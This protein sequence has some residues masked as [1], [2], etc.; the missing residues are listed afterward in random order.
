MKKK[1][2]ASRRH[3]RQNVLQVRVMTPRIAWLRFL[4][5]FG[6]LTKLACV[7]AI[8]AALGWAVWR[9]MQ[10]A[11]YRNPDFRLQVIDLNANPVIDEIRLASVIGLDLASNPSLFDINVEQATEQLKALP[12]IVDVTLERHLPDTLTVRV[13]PRVPK[14]W[15]RCEESGITEVRETGGLLVD[16]DGVAYHCPE[17]QI[18]STRLLPVI[19]L[20]ASEDVTMISG[21]RIDQPELNCALA[22]IKAICAVD[23]DGMRWIDSIR[24]A[25]M[26]S[27][28]LVTRDGT[29]ATFGLG[30]HQRQIE[31]L[32][33]ALAHAGSRGYVIDTIN[34][35]PKYN[36]PITIRSEIKPPKAIPVVID[37]TAAMDRADEKKSTAAATRN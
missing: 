27:L 11:F 37:E 1:S 4:G 16:Q 35:I 20:P 9:G 34:L 26:W 25:N 32:R 14:A 15:I 2:T 8:L 13:T 7:L 5:F 33:A 22:L 6:S 21:K 10:V 30:D 17:S 23:A 31:N 19:N 29:I 36:T 24:Q 3:S 28:E 12:E 18:E